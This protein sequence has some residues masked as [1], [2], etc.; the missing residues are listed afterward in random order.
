MK[1]RVSHSVS[2]DMKTRRISE[3]QVYE[4]HKTAKQLSVYGG[5]T[6]RRGL[7]Q[8]PRKIRGFE[9]HPFRHS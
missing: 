6:R 4:E 1:F 7:S 5:Q 3:N 2:V 8:V 9:A